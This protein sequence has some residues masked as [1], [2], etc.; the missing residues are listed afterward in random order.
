MYSLE[1]IADQ[2]GLNVRTVRGYVRSG[3]LKAVRI[4]KQYRVSREDLEAMTG[5][6]DRRN[7]IPR[8]PQVEV[9]SVVQIDALGKDGAARIAEHLMG[10]A[11]ARRVDG[12]PLRVDTIYDQERAGMK[13]VAMGSL[14]ATADLFRL[15]GVLLEA[16]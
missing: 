11:K 15:L 2:L 8:L 5:P 9:S 3:R 12:S 7:A 1:Q 10:A 6:L 16:S 14:A 4:G 13:V